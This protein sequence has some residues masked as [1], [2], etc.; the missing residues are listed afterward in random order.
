MVEQ[1]DGDG[2][3][4]PPDKKMKQLVCSHWLFQSAFA[5]IIIVAGKYFSLGLEPSAGTIE[6][7]RSLV[8][9]IVPPTS[10]IRCHN[11]HVANQ[12]HV[13]GYHVTQSPCQS[14][15]RGLG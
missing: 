3:L 12:I 15:F 14:N 11:N 9:D 8:R 13:L 7:P 10:G 1:S 4:P 2:C 5:R 6:G